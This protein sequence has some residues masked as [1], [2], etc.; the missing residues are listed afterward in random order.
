M[1]SY[2]WAH[3]ST[4]IK[5]K[6][7]RTRAPFTGPSKARGPWQQ[8]NSAHQCPRKHRQSSWRPLLLSEWPHCG[9][10]KPTVLSTLPSWYHQY[11]NPKTV[12]L[13]DPTTSPN[14]TKFIKNSQ[15]S[16]KDS[17]QWYLAERKKPRLHTKTSPKIHHQEKVIYYEI[18][19]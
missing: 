7:C 2:I 6:Y 9:H 17:A 4:I 12:G 18:T 13:S 16:D 5:E 3:V 11:L 15:K 10:P 19:L 1:S 8:Q 14:V